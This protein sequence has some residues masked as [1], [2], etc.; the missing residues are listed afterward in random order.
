[1]FL[2]VMA[3]V[4]LAA[5]L[6]G[7]IPFGYLI[8][9]WHDVDILRQGS[10]N[11]GATNVGRVLGRRHGILVF[12]LDFAKGAVP[13]LVASR[14]ASAVDSSLPPGS[15]E[16][17][18]ALAA[19][20]GHL[21]PVYLGFRGGKGVATGAG[22]MA[23]LFPGPTLG[24]LL[25]WLA[26]LS[27]TRYVSLA[28]LTAAA[29]LCLLRLVGISEPFAADHRILTL[30]CLVTAALV[31]VRHRSN[32][33]RLIHGQENRLRDTATMLVLSKILHV[34]AVG[35]WFGSVVFFT[36]AALVIFQSF[37]GLV[38]QSAT[39][40]SSPQARKEEAI[41]PSWL[42]QTLTKEQA[43]Q[44]AGLA[45]GPIFPSYFLLEGVCGCIA[46]ISALGWT[47]AAPG[48][49]V[50]TLRFYILLAALALVLISWPLALEVSDLRAKRFAADAAVAA[51]AKASFATWHLYSL[52]LNM[53]TLILVTVAMALAA[54][55]PSTAKIS[56]SRNFETSATDDK[57]NPP[58]P[59]S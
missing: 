50:H 8:A 29:V 23:V 35:L 11:I 53:L 25:T 36:F 6:L 49:T 38:D 41:R 55:L 24:A 5:Y 58:V 59:A 4:A 48:I 22:L 9:R 2:L 37:E 13:V 7:A 19:F 27:A 12:A 57:A 21:F 51:S 17:T 28:S 26:V 33:E 44:L 16:V 46:L 32:I 30:F 3:G 45:V 14:L 31:M 54:F 1:M 56:A 18:A 52:T 15:L 43:S 39:L 10:G 20:V 34:L 42:P 40:P 47:R